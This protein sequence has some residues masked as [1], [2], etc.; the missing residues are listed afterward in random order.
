MIIFRAD[1]NAEIGSGH[2]IRCLSI[3][4][5]ARDLGEECIFISSSDAMN[6]VIQRSGY[7]TICMQTD[8]RDLDSEDILAQLKKFDAPTVF[9]DSY[10]ASA[11]YLITIKKF[12][13]SV[14]RKL[15]YI[16]DIKKFAY[17]CDVLVNY[18]IHASQKEYNNIY[19]GNKA[20]TFLLG[21]SYAPLRKQFLASEPRSIREKGNSILVSTGGSDPANITVE[22][23][24]FAKKSTKTFHFIIGAVNAHKS[25]IIKEA[26]GATNL[27]FHENVRNMAKLMMTCDVAISAAGSTLY[28]LCATQ[29]P[30][31]TYTIAKNQIPIAEGFSSR[32]I[33]KNCGD[34]GLCG[35]KQIATAMIKEAIDLCNDYPKRRHLSSIMG[36]VTDGNGAKRIAEQVL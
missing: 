2:I 16:D 35:S 18:Q 19:T 23:I 4:D 8:Y 14:G 27:V 1:G 7:E 22:L 26:Q 32:G 33:I 31:L 17:P 24:R 13:S 9:V 11:K 20:P 25:E 6:A 15:I 34:V 3:A 28:E 21:T 12:C 36:V 10:Y 29:T 30:T 5:A